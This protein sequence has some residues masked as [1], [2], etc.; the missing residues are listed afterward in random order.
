[1]GTLGL[2]G[3]PV[4]GAVEFLQLGFLVLEAL[5]FFEESEVI[6]QNFFDVGREMNGG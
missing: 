3:R 1:M 6:E 5:T 4:L 2:V